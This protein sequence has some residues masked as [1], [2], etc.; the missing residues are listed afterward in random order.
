MIRWTPSTELANLHGAMD[1]LFED[2]FGPTTSSG[3]NGQR[4]VPTYFLPLDVKEV[5]NGYE[6]TAP[7]PGFKPEEVDVTFADG[8]LKISAEHSQQT[9]K[10]HAGYLRREVSFGNYQRAIQLPGD[11]KEDDIS[12]SFDNG[13]L[14]VMVPKVPR[15]QPKKI[16]V[17]AGSKKQ[18]VGSAS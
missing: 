5:E 18:L 12:A 16:Q 9:S 1:R 17:T 2:F 8:V 15:P 10:E 4:L 11:V 7:I 3:G 6:I 14:T 13:M